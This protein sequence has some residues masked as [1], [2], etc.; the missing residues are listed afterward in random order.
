MSMRR[1]LV[2][3]ALLLVLAAP[4][5][6]AATVLRWGEV[7]AAD[8]PSVQMIDRIGKRVAETTQGRVTIQAFPAS[9]LG[10]T[11]D[12][13]ENVALG[14]QQ[15]TTE[16]AAAISQFVP[17]LGVVEAP[18]VWRDAAHLL[19]GDERP[20]R[21]GSLPPA[22][23]EARDAGPRD[24]LL[25]RAPRHH[26]EEARPHRRR[27]AGVQAPGARERRLP[28]HGAR[29]GR[30]AD[31]DGVRRALPGAPPERGGRPGEP[32]CRR[33]TPASSSR[34]RSTWS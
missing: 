34:C 4:A 31:P 1:M 19:E 15:M 3:L 8:H 12:Q 24:D 13:I 11:K 21:P 32:A 10:S 17:A 5:A 22:R 30:E 27:H 2:S 26:D 6:E 28:R 20:D 23:R 9:Q 33:S 14:T 18:Y 16:G 25:R 29:V 7:L